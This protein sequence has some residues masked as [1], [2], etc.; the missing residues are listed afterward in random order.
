MSEYL[1][2]SVRRFSDVTGYGF[3]RAYGANQDTF[4]HYTGVVGDAYRTLAPGQR[5]RFMLAETERGS[6]AVDVEIL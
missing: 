4:V 1:T 2:G 5:V 3:I 6:R